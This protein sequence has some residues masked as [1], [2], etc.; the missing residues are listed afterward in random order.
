[1]RGATALSN[2]KGPTDFSPENKSILDKILSTHSH[3]PG[4]SSD[5]EIDMGPLIGLPKV[6]T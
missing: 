1:M 4:H 2:F 5:V 6:R 3:F